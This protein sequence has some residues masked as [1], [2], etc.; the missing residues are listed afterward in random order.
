MIKQFKYQALKSLLIAAMLT[1]L[2][3]INGCYY[4]DEENLYPQIGGCETTNITYSGTISQI[5]SGNCNSC[6][7]GSAPE[8]NVKTDNYTDLKTI[9]DNG[10]LWGVVN[11]ETGFS[12]MPKDRPKL[13]DCDLS[14]IRI[15]IDGGALNN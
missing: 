9:A 11:H 15:W 10:K 7:S 13:S 2:L 5:M 1:A 3:G 12:Q 6:H 14:K 8:G 4:D